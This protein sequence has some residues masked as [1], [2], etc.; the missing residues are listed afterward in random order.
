MHKLL[1][2]HAC[3]F[4]IE[5]Q[6]NGVVDLERCEERHALLQHRQIEAAALGMEDQVRMRI[7]RQ[8][9]ALPTYTCRRSADLLYQVLMAEVDTVERTDGKSSGN[10]NASGF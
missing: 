1:G 8:D 4:P 7:E 5:T 2:R 3:Q 10:A 6:D 9:H